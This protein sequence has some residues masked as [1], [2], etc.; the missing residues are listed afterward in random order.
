MW[1]SSFS[2]DADLKEI[3]SLKTMMPSGDGFIWKDI[4]GGRDE[5]FGS[6]ADYFVVVDKGGSEIHFVS[7]STAKKGLESVR[8]DLPN[9]V[10]NE[11]G[12]KFSIS[13]SDPT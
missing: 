4:K 9:V 3:K 7:K 2:R 12:G 13:L 5:F 8:F 6:V 11:M 10:K 1:H